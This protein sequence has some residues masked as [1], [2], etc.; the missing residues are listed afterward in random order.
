VTAASLAFKGIRALRE[1]RPLPDL[2]PPAWLDP[3]DRAAY[4]VPRGSHAR[5]TKVQLDAEAKPLLEQATRRYPA[6]LAERVGMGH[7][8][9][10]TQTMSPNSN[11]CDTR[12]QTIGSGDILEMRS[13]YP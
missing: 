5:W 8:T 11:F 3:P 12:P 13:L 4:P 10:N 1:H 2:T 7:V 9:D 6:C